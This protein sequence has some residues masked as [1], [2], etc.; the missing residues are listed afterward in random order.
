[1]SES[2][3]TILGVLGKRTIRS[4]EHVLCLSSVPP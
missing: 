2:F 4:H 1:M 3:P